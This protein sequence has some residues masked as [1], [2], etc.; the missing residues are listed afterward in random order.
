MCSSD[1]FNKDKIKKSV[2]QIVLMAE[3]YGTGIGE[4][5][6][7][8]EKEYIPMTQ[9]IPGVTGQAAIGVMEK[10][11]VGVK[12]TPIN[13]KNFLWDP[14]GTTVNDCMGVAIEKP[15]SFHKIVEGIERGIYRKVEIK[16]ESSQDD[17]EASLSTDEHYSDDQLILMTYY[18]LVPREYLLQLENNEDR[19]STRLNS[20][21]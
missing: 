14:N 7:K 18:G 20:S 17:L 21:H 12:L 16:P 4:I 1:L 9:P 2:D 5:I 11:R 19:K 6:V 10:D 3:I 8:K 15:V 13:P